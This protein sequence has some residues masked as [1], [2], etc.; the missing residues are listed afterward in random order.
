MGGLGHV[1]HRMTTATRPGHRQGRRDPAGARQ[2]PRRRGH[3][4]AKAPAFQP[5]SPERRSATMT[6]RNSRATGT[7]A[8]EG[9]LMARTE[10]RTLRRAASAALVAAG[11]LAVVACNGGGPTNQAPSLAAIADQRTTLG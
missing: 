2:R 7:G 1:A 3:G 8:L 4:G 11:A 6:P 9:G 10:P 5:R